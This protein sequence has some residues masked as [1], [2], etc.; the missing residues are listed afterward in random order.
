VLSPTRTTRIAAAVA[1]AAFGLAACGAGKKS[2]PPAA[3]ARTTTTP[4]T[5][6]SPLDAY[7]L[8]EG[9]GGFSVF[10]VPVV[11]PTIASWEKVSRSTAADGQRVKAEGFRGALEQATA[12]STGGT[13]LDFVLEVASAAAARTEQAVE[14]REDI[15]EQ[16]HYGVTRFT[17]P[18]IPGSVGIGATGGKKG[19]AANVLFTEGRCLLLVGNDEVDARYKAYVVAGAIAL[20]RRTVA[21]PGACKPVGPAEV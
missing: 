4:Q 20:Y 19:S 1:I 12:T 15:A 3:P 2:S 17:V 13:G 7:L 6:T 5:V 18:G 9:E 8:R 11:Q 10:S 21:T 16:G 14:L